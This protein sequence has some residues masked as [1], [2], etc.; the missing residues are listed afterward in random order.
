[1]C[2]NAKR[3]YC[4]TAW[5]LPEP[6]YDGI[7][8]ICWG[9][10]KCPTTNKEHY[11]GFVIFTRTHR[12]RNAKRLVG[13][14][15]DCHLEHRRGTRQQARDYCAKDGRFTEWGQF[16]RLTHDDLFKQDLNFLKENYP[17]FFCRY[18]KGLALLKSSNTIK[19]R[20]VAVH[21]L[22]GDPGTGK[23]R[24]V[25]EMDDVYK[26]DHPY[27][28]WD[29]Y[30]GEKILLIDDYKRGAIDRGFLLNILDGYKLRLETKGGHVWASWTKVYITTN[31][32][33]GT[34]LD[35]AMLRRV[36]DIEHLE[37]DE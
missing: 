21:I 7:R 27:K 10:E 3:D 31:F 26:L 16:E 19:W 29:G 11:Q 32:N 9:T 25:M 15:D 35:E 28:W 17:A 5:R 4:F 37:C 13:G 2:D 30:F 20:D 1:M 33:P 24:R 14:G 36:T 6:E 34:W 22:W 18:Y 8:Y 23:T 12:L